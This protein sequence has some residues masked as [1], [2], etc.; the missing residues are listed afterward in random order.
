LIWLPEA[1][2]DVQRFYRFLAPK[3]LHAARRA[4]EAVDQGVDLLR[5]QP[6]IGRLIDDWPENYR[7]WTIPFGDNAYVVWYRIDADID[8][9]TILAVRHQRESGYQSPQ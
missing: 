2:A 4:V 6:A 9:V 8:V 7:E 1:A 5:T 3:S